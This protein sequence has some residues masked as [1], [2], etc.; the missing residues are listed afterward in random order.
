MNMLVAGSPQIL[1][2]FNGLA[3]MQIAV[4]HTGNLVDPQNVAKLSA[5]MDLAALR[6]YCLAL[7][8]RICQI[9]Q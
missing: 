7:G 1:D 8:R 3:R 5:T 9:V 4:L 6:A 2:E